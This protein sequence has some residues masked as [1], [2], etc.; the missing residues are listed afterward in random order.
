MLGFPSLG[1]KSPT[2]KLRVPHRL[3]LLEEGLDLWPTLASKSGQRLCV[4]SNLYSMRCIG[5]GPLMPDADILVRLSE[6][7]TT[8]RMFP[9]DDGSCFSLCHFISVLLN[10]DFD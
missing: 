2:P 1:S 9:S 8:A 5:T 6:C 3:V 7:S 10:A 4:E